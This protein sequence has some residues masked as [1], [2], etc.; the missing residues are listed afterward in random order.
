MMKKNLKIN[1][2][3]E[4][5]FVKGTYMVLHFVVQHEFSISR[6]NLLVWVLTFIFI[7]SAQTGLIENSQ[8]KITFESWDKKKKMQKHSDFLRTEIALNSIFF[9]FC[10]IDVESLISEMTLSNLFFPWKVLS[11]A[12]S[13]IKTLFPIEHIPK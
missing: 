13:S 1:Y 8:W 3:F 12:S 7:I 10:G 4:F 6:R 2:F 5:L 11:R 9:Y